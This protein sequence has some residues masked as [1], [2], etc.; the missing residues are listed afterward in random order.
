MFD[1]KMTRFARF[2]IAVCIALSFFIPN[3]TFAAKPTIDQ[4]KATKVKVI[5]LF[6][7]IKFVDWP[8]NFLVDDY[9]IGVVGDSH[10]SEY[11]QSIEGWEFQGKKVKVKYFNDVDSVEFCHILFISSELSDQVKTIVMKLGFPPILTVGET[12]EFS[13]NGG[14]IQFVLVK[15]NVRFKINQKAAENL[16]LG[17]SSNLLNFSKMGLKKY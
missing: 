17:I 7:F 13:D 9:I 10:V 16:G 8:Q 6:K 11:L 1:S 4:T 5:F 3:H 15:N 14:I 2:L 12:E